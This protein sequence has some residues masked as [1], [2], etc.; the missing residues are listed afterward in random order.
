MTQVTIQ[1]VICSASD[2]RSV[3]IDVDGQQN[4]AERVADGKQL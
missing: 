4:A 2:S 3:D 1:P